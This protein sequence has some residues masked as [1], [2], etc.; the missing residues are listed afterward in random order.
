MA[1]Q[2]G[3]KWLYNT[4]QRIECWVNKA[5]GTHFHDKYGNGNTSQYNIYACIACLIHLALKIS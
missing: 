1:E 2:T 5:I 3:H 4:A